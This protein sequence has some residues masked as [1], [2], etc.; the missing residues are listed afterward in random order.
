MRTR[1]PA[2]ATAAALAITS[3][4]VSGP[5]KGQTGSDLQAARDRV[6]AL[7]TR[8]TREQAS[9]QSLQSQ[10][11]D[12]ATQVG[13][14]Q[15]ELSSI[16]GDL[17]TTNQEV[18][19]IKAELQELHR[20]IRDRARHLY[21]QGPL[22]L[23]GL[24]LGS[25]SL[26][27]FIGRIG[28]ARRVAARDG[29][30]M[31]DAREAESKLRA[32]QDEQKRLE[33]D[34]AGL[35]SALRSRQNALTDVFARQQ[36][37]L[38]DLAESKAEALRLVSDLESQLGAGALAGLRRVAGQGMTISYGEWASSFLGSLGAPAIRN[39]M[40]AVVA[41]EA[42]EGTQATWNPLATTK[43]MPGATRYNSHGVK[44]YL[45]KEQGV[46]ASILTLRLPNRG[47]EP[48]IARLRAGAEAMKT[49][50]A[51]RDSLWCSGCAGGTY[52]VGFI[53]AV[54]RYYDRYAN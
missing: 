1:V 23:V 41:W 5:V 19:E 43:D 30:L 34:Q 12:L 4:A 46:E 8:I 18:D 16:R 2:L 15:G 44:N 45:S 40:I 37:V 20:L 26:G 13:R 50:E 29:Q 28:Y 35:V 51:I 9:V 33:R 24:A 31:L 38:A 6:A 39:N 22:D 42:A 52:V 27:E 48:V 7:E 14:E 49:A 21:K 11:R 25:E 32:I 36:G 54:T 53:E 47:Y 17:A 3:L 10:L